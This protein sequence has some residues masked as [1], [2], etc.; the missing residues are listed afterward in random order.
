MSI[1][2]QFGL[3]RP[4][5]LQATCSLA[6]LMCFG[7][8]IGQFTASTVVLPELLLSVLPQILLSSAVIAVISFR[9]HPRLAGGVAA[10]SV[11][12]AIPMLTFSKFQSPNGTVCQPEECLTVMTINMWGESDY[13][14]AL[15]NTVDEY[16]PD[17]LAINEATKN[18]ASA[19]S[20][21]TFFSSF[22]TAI[23]ATW[24]NMPRGMG[25]PISLFSREP[26]I[27]SDKVL[28][29]DTGRRAYIFADLGGKWE[30][31]RVVVTHAMTPTSPS[32][33]T[34]RNK[35]LS[36]TGDI[37]EQSESYVLLGDFNLTAWS[38]T[39][40]ALPGRRAGDPRF[41]MTWP[42]QFPP[43]GMSIDHIMFSDDLELVEFRV[44][45]SIGSDHF[46]ILARFKRKSPL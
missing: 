8:M 9:W 29:R 42:S 24:L 10:I 28:R 26:I 25:N 12:A 1:A 15:S 2:N 39:F 37:A 4:S 20:R 5:V 23:H 31:V 40:R 14:P 41:A 19:A 22:D 46:P 13:L 33:L 17:I 6:I 3:V 35:L 32:G 16:E 7:A 30:G 11:L 38:P 36:V 18:S 45:G 34:S 27:D 43:L 21:R 44:L